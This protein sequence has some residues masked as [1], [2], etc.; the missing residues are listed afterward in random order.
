MTGVGPQEPP[1]KYHRQQE[2]SAERFSNGRDTVSQ[3]PDVFDLD[4]YLIA[5]AERESLGAPAWCRS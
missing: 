1:A 3:R 5:F 2:R 4:S